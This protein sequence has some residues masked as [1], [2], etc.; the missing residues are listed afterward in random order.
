MTKRLYQHDAY[1]KQFDAVVLE[2]RPGNAPGHW[3][4]VLDRT[5][6]YPTSGGQP[7]DTGRLGPCRVVDVVEDGAL[8]LH[9]CHGT[10]PVVGSR[11]GGVVDWDRRYDFMQQHTGQHLLSAVC[12]KRTQAVTAGFHLGAATVTIDLD[13]ELTVAE[14]EE[15]ER[16]VNS[17]VWQ[18]LA[19]RTVERDSRAPGQLRKV[20]SREGVLRVV[21]VEG[22]D[23]SACGGTHVRTTSEVGLVKLGHVERSRGKF[24]VHF[25][26]GWRALDEYNSMHRIARA[27]ATRLSVSV[28]GLED[29]VARLQE[30]LA[31]AARAHRQ[32]T[33]RLLEWEARALLESAGQSGDLTVVCAVLDG[34]EP[35]GMG[36]L[37][38]EVIRLATVPTVVLLGLAGDDA[39]LVLASTLPA[40]VHMGKLAKAAASLLGGNGGGSET[41]G[42]GA[43]PE[44]QKLAQALEYCKDQLRG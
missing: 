22:V 27:S 11:L 10:A 19:V 8:V 41:V 30:E 29:A 5:A 43:G 34:W 37:A 28:D 4:V 7:H 1:L 24:R 33:A 18:G 42:Q 21:E 16:E 17:L 40:P 9:L 13:R 35:A 31:A 36:G 38:R 44:V 3:W 20:S 14:L 12:Q 39:R 6:F 15:V 2:V 26:C 23:C 32:A 25:R